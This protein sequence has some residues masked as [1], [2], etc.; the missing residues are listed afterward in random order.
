MTLPQKSTI[1]HK[2]GVTIVLMNIVLRKYTSTPDQYDFDTYTCLHF[3]S[4][5]QLR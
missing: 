2:N 5:M 1:L 3:V 4:Y